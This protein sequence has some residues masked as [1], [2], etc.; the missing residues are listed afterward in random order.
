MVIVVIDARVDTDHRPQTRGPL[1]LG[2]SFPP[3]VSRMR[4]QSVRAWHA[5]GEARNA[6]HPTIER[7]VHMVGRIRRVY[8]AYRGRRGSSTTGIHFDHPIFV[9]SRFRIRAFGLLAGGDGRRHTVDP[10]KGKG[11]GRPPVD[12]T[13]AA[14]TVVGY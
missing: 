2:A 11:P 9:G 7:T 6:Y 14:E 12:S 4:W 3:I 8:V 5:R 13:T 1:V 10:G